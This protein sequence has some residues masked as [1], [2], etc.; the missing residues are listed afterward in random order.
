[1]FRH[2]FC[3]TVI[4]TVAFSFHIKKW[5]WTCWVYSN[6]RS[7]M[8]LYIV[9]QLYIVVLMWPNYTAHTV[10]VVYPRRDQLFY[11]SISHSF[12]L[13]LS[14]SLTLFLLLSVYQSTILSLSVIP[15][16]YIVCRRIVWRAYWRLTLLLHHDTGCYSVTCYFYAMMLAVIIQFY[17]KVAWHCVYQ[18]VCVRHVS[19]IKFNS[20]MNIRDFR[21]ANASIVH[22]DNKQC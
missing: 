21:Y 7:N 16:Y 17:R 3:A 20:T 11:H 13:P 12:F 19:M 18:P 10:S 9:V 15:R 2:F 4:R 1:M 8:M 6:F 22:S 14:L 5:E